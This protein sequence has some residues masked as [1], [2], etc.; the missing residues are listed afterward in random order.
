MMQH[1]AKQAK[2]IFAPRGKVCFGEKRFDM[3]MSA[4]LN[5]QLCV[6]RR[7][8]HDEFLRVE[9]S[10]LAVRILDAIIPGRD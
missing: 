7:V 4:Y 6:S 8:V 1:E 5:A 10:D 3:G 2:A 9:M